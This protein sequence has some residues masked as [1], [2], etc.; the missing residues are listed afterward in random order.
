MKL[1]KETVELRADSEIEAK[2]IIESFRTKAIEK[3]FSIVAAGY[4]YKT[5]KSK[6]E[7]IDEAWICK[8]VQNF[9][10]VWEE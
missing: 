2:E 8:I 9:G 6:G 4:T 7:I 10:N 3:N 5:K 1:L